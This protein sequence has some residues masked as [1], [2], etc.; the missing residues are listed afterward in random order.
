MAHVLDLVVFAPAEEEVAVLVVCSHVA[1]TVHDLGKRLLQGIAHEGALGLL[2]GGVIAQCHRGAAH[3]NLA[4]DAGL[5]DETVVAVE[6]H[7]LSVGEGTTQR[8]ALVVGAPAL[9][10]VIGAVA[11]DLGGAIEVHELGLGQAFHPDGQVLEGHHLAAEKDAPYMGQALPVE[12][13]QAAHQAQRGNRPGH[14]SRVAGV[15]VFDECC[16]LGE[17][18]AGHNGQLAAGGKRAVDVLDRDVEV[19]RC[20]VRE[21]IVAGKPKRRGKGVD[22]VDDGAV[23]HR[24]ALGRPG[25]TRGEQDIGGVAVEHV[26]ANALEQGGVDLRGHTVRLDEPCVRKRRAGALAGRVV[27]DDKGV[28]ERGIHAGQAHVRRGRVDGHVEAACVQGAQKRCERASALLH[29]H[30]DGL[31]IC[32]EGGQGA[33]A[34]TR[35]VEKLAIGEPGVLVAYRARVRAREGASLK[36]FQDIVLRHGRSFLCGPIGGGSVGNYCNM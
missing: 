30:H 27:H 22:E 10:L 18:P 20:L 3:A 2:A 11:G 15:H 4:L 6:Q 26:G 28:A 24:H 5:R 19:K 34:R 9:H 16:G 32:T 33:A 23:A 13:M 1:R 7:H 21:D 25:G 36:V 17:E 31:R 8:Q 35:R 14:D 12:G 29:E